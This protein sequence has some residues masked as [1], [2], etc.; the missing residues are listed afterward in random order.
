[1]TQARFTDAMRA[2]G[3]RVGENWQQVCAALTPDVIDT[4]LKSAVDGN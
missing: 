4:S 3:A 1:M 2:V